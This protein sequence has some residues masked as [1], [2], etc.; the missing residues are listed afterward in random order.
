MADNL[1]A[2]VP[3]FPVGVLMAQLSGEMNGVWPGDVF[4]INMIHRG[5]PGAGGVVT[6]G[7]ITIVTQRVLTAPEDA[8]ALAF[9]PT[10]V[11]IIGAQGGTLIADLPVG[12]YQGEMVF[13]SDE[14]RQPLG[15]GV[16]AYW[17]GLDRTWRRIRDDAV[18][19]VIP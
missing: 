12:A 4:P 16:L 19:A 18:V 6:T 2:V 11:P 3:N 7:N 13:V 17:D 8:A 10:H 5:R 15:V 9:F 1:Y 14:A